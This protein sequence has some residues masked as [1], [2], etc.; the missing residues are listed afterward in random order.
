MSSNQCVC[1]DLVKLA[2]GRYECDNC[3]TVY[4]MSRAPETPARHPIATTCGVC[5]GHYFPEHGG[6]PCQPPEKTGAGQ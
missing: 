1:L 4:S 2:D 6:K 5:G 3:K